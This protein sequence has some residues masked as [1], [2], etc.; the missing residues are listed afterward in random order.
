MTLPW[1]SVTSICVPHTTSTPRL[2][3]TRNP[4]L[5]TFSTFPYFTP[6]P[7]TASS[8]S[9]SQC[10]IFLSCLQVYTLGVSIFH[11]ASIVF[12]LI[13]KIIQDLPP[14]ISKDDIFSVS[15]AEPTIF[16][17]LTLSCYR[18]NYRSTGQSQPLISF[19]VGAIQPILAP[20]SPGLKHMFFHA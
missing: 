18:S 3:Q 5:R 20:V 15:L 10:P 7:S 14:G 4:P 11:T 1:L 17:M 13:I 9:V 6:L 2:P 8:T 16:T 19:K 12:K